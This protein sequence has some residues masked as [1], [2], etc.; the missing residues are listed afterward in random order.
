MPD[1]PESAEM[2][3]NAADVLSRGMELVDLFVNK[4]YLIDIDKNEPIEMDSSERS[5]T[6]LSLYKIDKIVFDPNENINEKLT[7]VYSALCNFGSSVILIISSTDTG[8]EFY[9]GTRNATNPTIAGDILHKSLRGNFPGINIQKKKTGE[10]GD[11]LKEKLPSEYANK[12]IT[13]VSIVPG[14]RDAEDKEHFVQGIEKFID[15][16]AGENYTAIFVSS[17]VSKQALEDKKRGYEELYTALSQ[18]SQFVM[19]YGENESDAVALGISKGFS[20]SINDGISDTTGKNSGTNISRSRSRNSG[21]TLGLFG[22]GFNWGHGKSVSRGSY[23]GTSESHTENYSETETTSDTQTD[24][25]TTTTGTSASIQMTRHNKTVEEL[26]EKID[27]QLDRIKQCEAYGLWD[28]ACYFIADSED[29]SIV[30][31]N[32]FKALVAGEQTSVENSFINIWDNEFDNFEDKSRVILERLRYGMHPKFKYLPDNSGDFEEQEISVASLVSG[33]ELP[34]LM[35]LPHKSVSGVTSIE[36]AEFGRNVFR[37]NND[38]IKKKINLGAIYHMGEVY[39]NNRVVLNL[40]SL[41][42]HCFV[43]GS[44][45]S[46]K[47]NTTYKLVEELTKPENGVKFLVIEPAKG[48]YK[49][50]LGKM[51]GLNVFTSNPKYYSMLAINPFEFNEEM[52][53]LEHLDRLIEIFSACWP[54]YAAMPA[55]LKNSFERAYISHGWDLNHSTYTDLGN[56][57]FP[58]FKDVCEIL[59]VILNESEFSAE[60]KGNYVGSLVTRVE[61]LTNGLVGQIFNGVAVPDEKLFNENTIVD[62]SRIGSTETKALIMGVLVLKLSEFRQCT[63]KGTNLPL[64]HVTIMEEAHNLLKRCS[65]DQGQESSNVQGKSVEMI[66]NSIAEMRTYGEGFIIVDQSPT[67]VDISAIKN[68]NTKIIMRLPEAADCEAVGHSIGLNDDQI[69]ELSRLDKGVAAV[70]Q[71]DWLE[72]VLTKIDMANVDA[73]DKVLTNDLNVEK[74][75]IAD[76]IEEV[77]NENKEKSYHGD[78]LKDTLLGYKC[79]NKTFLDSYEKYIDDFIVDYT[80]KTK[81]NDLLPEFIMKILNCADL[82]TMYAH[83]LPPGIQKSSMLT[84]EITKKAKTWAHH[85]YKNLDNYA[86]IKKDE[87]KQAVLKNIIIYQIHHDKKRAN[88]YKVVLYCVNNKNKEAKEEN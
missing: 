81:G 88:S 77:I 68:T 9:I 12:A 2:K 4:N 72:A 14:E 33:V 64:Q 79:D 53:V 30:A 15:S 32:T 17:P 13:S 54:L 47:S 73:I 52:H 74:D 62:L 82:I 18:C 48:E 6:Y 50:D 28:S 80:K 61:S 45:G 21:F 78:W 7:S 83:E 16:M 5:F 69:T 23:S 60:T 85:I 3:K 27:E 56:G 76:L 26:L 24:T 29:T 40:E 51:K 38:E 39:K 36:S 31:A 58:N 66:S 10:I 44:T 86:P 25:K 70:F 49:I 65:T 71:N 59:P 20:K 57:K 37:K 87:I 41:T 75:I 67:A 55:V 11:L 43:C 35:G 22:S 63:S 1:F 46:G 84:P 34:I 19:T 8:V 42:S